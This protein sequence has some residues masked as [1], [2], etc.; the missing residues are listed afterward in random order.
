MVVGN[1]QCNGANLIESK[2]QLQLELSLAEFS[3]SLFNIFLSILQFSHNVIIF[4]SNTLN[5]NRRCLIYLRKRP[6]KWNSAFEN[7]QA[8]LFT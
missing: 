6:S 5:K 2:S 1:H 4:L 7:D 8:S 3:P